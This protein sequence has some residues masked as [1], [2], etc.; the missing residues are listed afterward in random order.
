MH[1]PVV[2]SHT[3]D[4]DAGQLIDRT[5]FWSCKTD[6]INYQ[7]SGASLNAHGT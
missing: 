2:T 6:Q 3:T 1:V 5:H 7:D 4:T